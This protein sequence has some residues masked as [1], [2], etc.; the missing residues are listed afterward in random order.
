MTEGVALLRE[1]AEMRD[2]D[3][4]LH[5]YFVH[6]LGLALR[7]TGELIEAEKVFAQ[8]IEVKD[9]NP[10]TPALGHHGRGLALHAQRR[11]KSA[12]SAFRAAA[13]IMRDLHTRG[14]P[15]PWWNVRQQD[16]T[17]LFVS[18]LN[19]LAQLL[20]EPPGEF[21][22]AKKLF[23]EVFALYEAAPAEKQ[24]DPKLKQE[25]D[26]I[27]SKYA[28]VLSWRGD[29]DSLAKSGAAETAKG[30][31]SLLDVVFF[32]QVVLQNVTLRVLH[33]KGKQRNLE[34]QKEPNK[35]Q[36]AE[37]EASLRAAVKRAEQEACKASSV[38]QALHLL[39]SFRSL[40]G[41]ETG[42]EALLLCALKTL[43]STPPVVSSAQ[44]TCSQDGDGRSAWNPQDVHLDTRKVVLFSL[45]MLMLN[46]DKDGTHAFQARVYLEE[47]LS[48]A[49]VK[50][51]ARFECL[52]LITLGVIS[53]ESAEEGRSHD[54]D[55]RA[56]GA[57]M[58]PHAR[59]G[60]SAGAHQASSQGIRARGPRSAGCARVPSNARNVRLRGEARQAAAA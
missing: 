55:T 18:V 14:V 10:W 20:L 54:A 23:D 45:G 13:E 28:L 44:C 47:C 37:A 22:E 16:S 53:A 5:H 31:A 11:R 3:A 7:Q 25:V 32:H 52:R 40:C 2:I 42:A 58:Q 33:L 19:S 29:Q 24:R 21:A 30:D 6:N 9:C 35:T 26:G 49:E 17:V 12:T 34:M 1:T 46:Q 51:P 38:A 43:V 56:A 59:P 15:Q 48:I 60:S 50:L 39:S 57:G 36:V 4:E 8:L 41:D 27:R